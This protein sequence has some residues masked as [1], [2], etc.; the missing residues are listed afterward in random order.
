MFFLFLFFLSGAEGHSWLA[1]FGFFVSFV[2]FISKKGYTFLKCISHVLSCLFFFSGLGQFFALC[3]RTVVDFFFFF[4]WGEHMSLKSSFIFQALGVPDLFLC[5][6]PVFFSLTQFSHSL[7]FCGYII[8]N[9]RHRRLLVCRS[10]TVRLKWFDL[11][12]WRS[13]LQHRVWALQ[14]GESLCLRCQEKREEEGR[15]S[16]ATGRGKKT[17]RRDANGRTLLA[18]LVLWQLDDK[19]CFNYIYKLALCACR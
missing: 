18:T 7:S 13:L 4:V 9:K 3:S 10:W 16:H 14:T 1:T 15:W 5:P 6:L 2:V 8:V 17:R 12:P 19:V 11:F